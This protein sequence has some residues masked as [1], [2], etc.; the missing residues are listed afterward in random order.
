M[1]NFTKICHD[2]I[3]SKFYELDDIDYNWKFNFL[4]TEIQIGF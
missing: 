2:Q 1:K 3:L 4:K